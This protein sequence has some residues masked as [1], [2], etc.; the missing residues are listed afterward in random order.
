MFYSRWNSHHISHAGFGESSQKYQ[1]LFVHSTHISLRSHDKHRFC[2]RLKEMNIQARQFCDN[3]LEMLP[4]SRQRDQT[5][6]SRRPAVQCTDMRLRNI[7]EA[8]TAVEE[9]R[10]VIHDPEALKGRWKEIYGG[11]KPLYVEIGTGKGRFIIETA[12]AHPER[13]YIGIERFASVLYRACQ[14]MD[15]IPYSTPADREERRAHPE[16]D[17][18]FVPPGNLH[19]LSRDAENLTEFFAK[20]E[21]DGIFLN[22]S[23]P[24]PK[25]RHAKRRLTSGTFLSLYEQILADGAVLEFKTDNQELFTFSIEEI[26][27][28]E[29]WD[30]LVWTRDLARD[31]VLAAGNIETEYERKFAKLGNTIAKLIAVYHD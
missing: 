12:S 6:S 14:K 10:W 3:R 18:S 29:H 26:K 9:S 13:E 23:D 17:A 21:I 27:V 24:W 31:P 30:L 22:F 1:V 28:R 4:F 11:G 2:D 20:G 25:A 7:P 16:R 8:K 15:G 19:F 5:C